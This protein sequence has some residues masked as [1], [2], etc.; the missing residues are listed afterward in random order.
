MARFYDIKP[1]EH[2][3]DRY[4]KRNFEDGKFWGGGRT[5]YKGQRI[6]H[7]EEFCGQ[8]TAGNFKEICDIGN[9]GPSVNI[10]NGGTDLNHETVIITSNTHPAGWYRN[11]LEKDAKQ[12]YPIIRRVT[13]LYYFPALRQDGTDNTPDADNLPYYI[14]QTED[15]PTIQSYPCAI[16]HAT[17]HWPLPQTEQN[18]C[19]KRKWTNNEF[20]TYCLTGRLPNL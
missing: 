7:L 4:Y 1:D 5:A 14:D 17:K 15:L 16:N 2:Q 20:E 13:Q 11:M 8:E 3:R 12:W 19:N 18:I 9:E 6:I 10:K